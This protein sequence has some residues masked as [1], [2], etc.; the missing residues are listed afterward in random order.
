MKLQKKIKELIKKRNAVLLVHNYQINEIQEIADYLGDSLGLAQKAA[1][2]EADTIVFCGVKFM[3]ET[4]KILSPAKRVLLPEIDAGCPMANMITP[5]DILDLKK[6]HPKAKVVSYVNTTAEVKAVSDVCCTSS[7]AVEVVKN[8]EADKIIFTPDTNL[9]QWVQR[10]VDKKLIIW[11]GFCYVHS[12]ITPEEVLTTKNNFPD[13]P[14]IVHPECRKEV[15]DLADKVGSTGDMVRF[16]RESKAER[17]I[18]GTEE[19]LIDRLKRENPTKEFYSA[20]SPQICQNMKKISLKS[21]YFALE[22]NHYEINL[23]HEII[24]SANQA[25]QLMLEYS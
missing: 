24:N 11:D 22:N 9:G 4:A 7:N 2:T 23:S 12:R 20:G 10:F 16:A 8:I 15:I 21:V 19:G 18:I 6:K 5:E 13:A 3:A 17:I 14:V 25:L 1:E